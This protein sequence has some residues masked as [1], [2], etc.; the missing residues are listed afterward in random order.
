MARHQSFAKV[1]VKDCEV[2]LELH[3]WDLS[4][5]L[6]TAS[7]VAEKEG[8]KGTADRLAADADLLRTLSLGRIGPA[9]LTIKVAASTSDL[10]SGR[11]EE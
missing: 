9:T 6:L 11:G 10:L 7:R 1:E 4:A 2:E 5:S 8:M 3:L